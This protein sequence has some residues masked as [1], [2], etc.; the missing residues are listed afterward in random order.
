MH[1]AL[2]LYY[3]LIELIELIGEQT[4]PLVAANNND[5]CFTQVEL[6]PWSWAFSSAVAGDRRTLFRLGSRKVLGVRYV[7]VVTLVLWLFIHQYIHSL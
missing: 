5:G 7:V 4:P 6:E 2:N 3:L 1:V